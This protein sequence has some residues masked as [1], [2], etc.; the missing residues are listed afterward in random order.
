MGSVHLL[1]EVVDG[2][3]D[4]VFIVVSHLCALGTCARYIKFIEDFAPKKVIHCA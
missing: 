2:R 3:F 1:L 4:A